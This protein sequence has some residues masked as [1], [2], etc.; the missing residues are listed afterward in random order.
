[1]KKNRKLTV[2]AYVAQWLGVYSDEIVGSHPGTVSYFDGGLFIC[3][4]SMGCF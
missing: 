3:T 4:H 1:M 2:V